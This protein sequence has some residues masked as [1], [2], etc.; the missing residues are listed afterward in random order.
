M[1]LPITRRLLVGLASLGL[2]LSAAA[3]SD[4]TSRTAAAEASQPQKVN[5]GYMA[6]FNGASLVAV[7]EE[8]GI[9]A[10]HGLEPNLQVFTE[11]PLQVQ[12]LNAGD[13]DFGYL[14]PG[15][16]W[17]PASGQA[18][19]VAVNSIGLADRVIAQ[20]GIT[21]VADLKG[22]TVG[23][24]EGTSGDMILRLA[25]QQAGMSI[26]DIKTVAMDPTTVVTAFSSG[27][28]DAAGIWYPLI[29]TI[30][31]RVPG[32]VELAKNE[33]FRPQTTFPTVHVTRND[34][35]EEQP[36]LVAKM[37]QVIREANDYRAAHVEES[38]AIT[39]DFL[40]APEQNLAAEAENV[41]FLTSEEL[42]QKTREGTVEDWLASLNEL[43][44]Q[45]GMLPSDVDPATYYLGDAYTS[46]A[47]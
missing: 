8:Q 18:K 14:G 24:P 10:E 35:A 4:D 36:E 40:Q 2:A 6:D 16:L 34:V 13:L 45:A 42:D 30:R 12:A 21:S 27:Q 9:F 39:A 31:Q 3:C 38:V 44:L 19:I 7:A 41:S 22:K 46:A 25:L 1:R 43:F 37:V 23:V 17:L 26:D 15:A 47:E 28:I 33:D 32:L 11:G 5:V 29:D 20:P